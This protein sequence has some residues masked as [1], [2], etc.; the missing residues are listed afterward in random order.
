M[1]VQEVGIVNRLMAQIKLESK[2]FTG[3]GVL[4]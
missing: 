4:V 3:G 2:F 1:V